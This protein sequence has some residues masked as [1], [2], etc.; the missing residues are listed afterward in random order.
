[1]L[2]QLVPFNCGSLDLPTAESSHL[3]NIQLNKTLINHVASSSLRGR[4]QHGCHRQ[5]APDSTAQCIVQAGTV[6]CDGM[7]LGNPQAP[8]RLTP[9]PMI[10]GNSC[11][12]HALKPTA[13]ATVTSEQLHVNR[14]VYL[15]VQVDPAQTTQ[16][17]TMY[18]PIR[19]S[20][21]HWAA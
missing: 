19:S 10:V 3:H 17:C 5:V 20:S 11:T 4:L 14:L 6:L 2:Q 9:Q 12:C 16:D 18:G 7:C 13:C 8:S 21:K 1:M 15:P